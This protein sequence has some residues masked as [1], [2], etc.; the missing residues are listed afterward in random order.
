MP[1]RKLHPVSDTLGVWLDEI[2]S[3]PGR[4][5]SSSMYV[6]CMGN[7]TT[8]Q[9]YLAYKKLSLLFLDTVLASA[10]GLRGLAVH[11]LLT[12]TLA[13]AADCGLLLTDHTFCC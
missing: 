1:A 13:F 2:V 5:E 8:V 3:R 11:L 9:G 12:V 7:E 4:P 10:A 6:L